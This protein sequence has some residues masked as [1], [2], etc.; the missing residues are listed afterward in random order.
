MVQREG[1]ILRKGN[2]SEQ[3]YIFRYITRGSF[4]AYSWQILENKQR[5]IASFLSG[6]AA[7][8]EVS[9]ISDT[10]LSYAEVKAL[11]IG[12]PLIKKRVEVANKLD[13][14]KIASR[15]RQKQ[16]QELNDVIE[17]TPHKAAN[18]RRLSIIAMRD[19]D[20]YITNKEVVPNEERLAFGEELL[21]ALKSNALTGN[22]QVFDVYQGFRVILPGDMYPDKR[23]VYVESDNGGKYRCDIDE[24]KTFMGC[25]RTIDYLLE[26][27]KKRAERLEISANLEKKKVDEARLELEK[28]NPYVKEVE[29]L[30]NLLAEIDKELEETAKKSETK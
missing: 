13:R 5:F 1:R 8:R 23:Y 15:G 19:Y 21:D 7:A 10:V 6:T 16:M 18:L 9:D 3:V 2:T 20:E 24:D 28:D 30:K 27:L 25:S 26:G 11:A 12:N 22:E 17:T 14:A 4:D 29:A